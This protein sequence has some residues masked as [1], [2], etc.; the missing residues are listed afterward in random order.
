MFNHKA[1]KKERLG[2][3]IK[4]PHV[5]KT[6]QKLGVSFVD[7]TDLVTDGDL[8]E[9]NMQKIIDKCDDEHVATGGNIESKKLNIIHGNESSRK[10]TKR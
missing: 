2:M 9:Q 3:V 10:E 8:V 7:D 6:Q 1:I 4:S 5:S